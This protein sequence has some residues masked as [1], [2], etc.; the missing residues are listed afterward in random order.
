[1]FSEILS[2][3]KF[4]IFIEQCNTELSFNE[5]LQQQKT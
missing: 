5:N 2:L 3:Q 4:I 1:M